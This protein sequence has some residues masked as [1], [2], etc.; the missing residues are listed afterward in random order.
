MATRWTVTTL[1]T[2]AALAL[3]PAAPASEALPLPA[4]AV[5]RIPDLAARETLPIDPAAALPHGEF[6]SPIRT[7]DDR[8]TLHD[9]IERRR[10]DEAA[11]FAAG[12]GMW[13][14][15]PLRRPKF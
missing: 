8:A 1:A 6:A 4:P 14:D 13:I 2:A 15:V 10:A 5:V 7:A 9:A 11:R 12:A 3:A